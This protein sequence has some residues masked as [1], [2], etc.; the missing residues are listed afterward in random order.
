MKEAGQSADLGI[1]RISHAQMVLALN[2]QQQLHGRNAALVAE[3][4]PF[5]GKALDEVER[6]LKELAHA[7]RHASFG[8]V[9]EPI[10]GS[11]GELEGYTRLDHGPSLAAAAHAYIQIDLSPSEPDNATVRCIGAVGV[12]D[13][14]TIQLAIEVNRRKAILKQALCPRRP[15]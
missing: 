13:I 3:H 14:D 2:P 5:I 6:G 1:G 8:V 11:E 4:K 12:L 10:Y 7:V 9:F 15:R